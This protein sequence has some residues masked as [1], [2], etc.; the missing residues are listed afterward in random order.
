[1]VAGPF[2]SHT[3]NGRRFACD[4]EDD[5]KLKLSGKNNEVKPNG[6]GTT[7]VTQQRTIAS[8]D[9]INL[10][11]DL[12]NGDDEFLQD[13]KDS[14]EMF[15][16]SGT[17]NDGVVWSGKMQ[18]VDDMEISFKEGTASVSLQGHLEKQGV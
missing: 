3:F 15:D 16:Y 18:I 13:L 12:D 9:G 17:T 14:G 1:M 4:A 2:E 7:R 5:V 6:D 8:L 10:V 11:I